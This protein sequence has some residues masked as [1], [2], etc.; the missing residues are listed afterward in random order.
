MARVVFA[1]DR[2]G[3]LVVVLL[4]RPH[5][6]LAV[7]VAAAA[8]ATDAELQPRERLA[9]ALVDSVAESHVLLRPVEAEGVGCIEALGVA[10][11][12]AEEQARLHSLLVPVLTGLLACFLVGGITGALGFKLAGYAFTVPIALLLAVMALVPA[13]DDLQLSDRRHR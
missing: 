8:P 3:F 2:G 9:R 10:V 7:A 4:P 6:V 13:I 12:G 1:R 5:R 11:G